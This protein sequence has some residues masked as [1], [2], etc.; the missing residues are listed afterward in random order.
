MIN[1]KKFKPDRQEL[2]THIGLCGCI[3]IKKTKILN[4][5]ALH[6]YKLDILGNLTGKDLEFANISSTL[7]QK[8][9]LWEILNYL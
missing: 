3:E 8:I 6:N 2:Y 9:D 5:H 1:N 4:I 7:T